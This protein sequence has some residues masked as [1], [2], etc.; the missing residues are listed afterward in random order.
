MWGT[1]K[2]AGDARTPRPRTRGVDLMAD[3]DDSQPHGYCQCGCGELAPLATRTRASHG[4]QRGE[5]VRY[6]PGHN[7][8]DVTSPTY[9]VRDCGYI[10]PCWV[11][12]RSINSKGYGSLRIDGRN[13]TAHRIYYERTVG[14]VPDGLDLD[15]LCRNRACCNPEHL[16]PVSRAENV[17]RG[18]STRLTPQA[19]REI[20]ASTETQT[21]LADRYGVGQTMISKIRR[22]ECWA[23]LPV[24]P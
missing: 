18:A 9:E 1:T 24:E 8:R 20:R 22:R 6:I 17:Q 10:S 2:R 13:T 12:L 23:D 19:V 4:Y 14:P 16:E 15:H 7:T 3:R 11:W 5:P 21:V